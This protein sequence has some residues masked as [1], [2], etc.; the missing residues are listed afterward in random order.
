MTCPRCGA[1]MEYDFELINPP[2]IYYICPVCGYKAYK[3]KKI[4]GR[5][6]LQVYFY[7]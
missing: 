6:K 4:N 1:D 2:T 3:T 7:V 5:T